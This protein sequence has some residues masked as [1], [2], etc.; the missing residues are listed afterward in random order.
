MLAFGLS[1]LLFAFWGM[2]GFAL[3]ALLHTQRNLLQNAL[4][5]PVAG[6]ATTVIPIFLL[7][8]AGLP[9]ARFAVTLAGALL[10]LSVLLIWQLR[11]LIPLRQYMPF[12]GV[13]MLAL[14]MTGW[15]MLEFGFDWV[16]YSNDDMANYVLAAHRFLNHGF[17]DIPSVDAL[18]Y[19]RDYTLVYWFFHAIGGV[20]P[21]SELLLAWVI[22]VTGLTGHQIFMPVILAL[23]LVL[24][25][26]AGAL[27]HQARRFLVSALVTCLLLSLSALTSLGALYQL[28]AQVGGL[29]LLAGC[30]TLL[31]R[32]LLA[33]RTQ[34]ILLNGVLAGILVSASLIVYPE[35]LPFLGTALALYSLI[36]FI[37]ERLPLRALIVLLAVVVVVLLVSLQ[38]YSLSAFLFLLGQIRSGFIARSPEDMVFPYF[39]VPSGLATL[40]GLQPIATLSPEPLLSTSILVGAALLAAAA[41]ASILLTWR[42]QPAATLSLVMLAVGIRLFLQR[43]DFGLFKLAMFIQ[44]FMLASLTT[45]WLGVVRRPSWQI[46]P[47]ILLAI[48]GLYAQIG[49]VVRSRGVPSAHA[50]SFIEIP[51]GSRSG[52]VAEFRRLVSATDARHIL[53]DTA[54]VVLAKFQALYTRGRSASFPSR[55]FFENIMRG[56]GFGM[57]LLDLPIW[58][59]SRSI[60]DTVNQKLLKANF[61]LHDSREP[62]AV[63]EFL[64]NTVGQE[65]PHSNSCDIL[66]ATTRR[67]TI[68]NRRHSYRDERRNFLAQRCRHAYNHLIFIH[69]KLGQHYYGGNPARIGVYQLEPDILLAGHSMSGIGRHLLFQVI[70]PSRQVRLVL[71]VTATLKADG[72]NRLPPGAAI[73]VDRRLFP[74]L[75]RGSARVFSPPITARIIHDRAYV[76][77]DVGVEG[78]RFPERRTGLTALYG[79]DISRDRRWLVGFARDISLV[80]EADYG[81]LAPPSYLDTFP[82]GL[83][84]P[85][86]EY[87]G[88]YEDGWVSETAFFQLTQPNAPATVAVRGTVPMIAD[89]SFRTELTVLIDGQEVARRVLG[90]GEFAIQVA[91]LPGKGRRRIDLRF[92]NVQRLPGGDRRPVA[93]RLRSVGFQPIVVSRAQP[94]PV[95]DIVTTAMIGLGSG[96]RILELRIGRVYG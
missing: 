87:S 85:N 56:S 42:A 79:T 96:Q 18:V 58:T 78:Q 36:G 74:I 88:L 37:R 50:G 24:I 92:S 65:S 75:G 91:A 59:R 68:F 40:W 5:A 1:I 44:P 7:N 2:V 14:L 77:I 84:N 31:L 22:G 28:I 25:S 12:A 57:Q 20:R 49:Y 4:L 35:A 11:P 80:S 67:H 89:P 41:G 93:A 64:I 76:A 3:V 21:G 8:R 34:P 47:L 54:N 61:P 60:T 83:T 63:N 19:G 95:S 43:S 6:V 69:S 13:F 73:G 52:I 10:L 51:D 72:E 66:I 48:V 46:R 62:A 23:H 45:V 29:G 27:V 30:A 17:M 32:P 55:V 15:P 26:A 33:S 9:V 71:D 94:R 81:R 38:S 86:L 53:L 82:A 16:S 90:P 70:N 39:L